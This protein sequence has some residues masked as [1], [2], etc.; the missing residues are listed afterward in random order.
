MNRTGVRRD[1]GVRQL[2]RRHCDR[3]IVSLEPLNPSVIHMM[4]VNIPYYFQ[5]L[6]REYI[7]LV[8]YLLLEKPINVRAAKVVYRICGI[9][10]VRQKIR[11]VYLVVVLKRSVPFQSGR[12]FLSREIKPV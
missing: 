12:Y 11:S 1:R 10:V 4:V 8:R 3:L 6:P 2:E 9:H 7:L 5:L